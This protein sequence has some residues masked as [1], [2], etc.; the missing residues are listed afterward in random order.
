LRVL[1]YR[2]HRGAEV[3]TSHES[4]PSDFIVFTPRSGFFSNVPVIAAGCLVIVAFLVLAGFWVVGLSGNP[5]MVWAPDSDVPVAQFTKFEVGEFHAS[6][7]AGRT[8]GKVEKKRL[9]DKAKVAE[10]LG[11]TNSQKAFVDR[12]FGGMLAGS[13]V[14]VDLSKHV[15][16][17][18]RALG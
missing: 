11:L 16:L 4:A 17:Q 3:S 14:D 15:H 5:A 7:L 9:K 10:E 18:V 12:Q 6:Q 8:V 2:R 1:V 13:N